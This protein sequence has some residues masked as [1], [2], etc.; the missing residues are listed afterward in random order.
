MRAFDR[1]PGY[2]DQGFSD[3]HDTDRIRRLIWYCSNAYVQLHAVITANIL[4]SVMI[5]HFR[6]VTGSCFCAKQISG[7][8]YVCYRL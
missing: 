4:Y 1:F 7:K 2:A 6:D 5:S 8:S 3:V